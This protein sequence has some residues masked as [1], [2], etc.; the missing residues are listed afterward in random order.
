MVRDSPLALLGQGLSIALSGTLRWHS[1][2]R[3]SPLHGQGL[4]IAW[5][6]TLH[7][8]V[9]D[10]PL[11]VCRSLDN[12]LAKLKKKG[13]MVRDS[14]F[15]VRRSQFVWQV[16]GLHSCDFAA[17]FPPPSPPSLATYWSV[18]PSSLGPQSSLLLPCT[19]PGCPAW[20]PH[21]GDGLWSPRTLSVDRLPCGWG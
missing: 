12:S 1:L 7:C 10:S 20:P 2:A 15:H 8:I 9:R 6:G 16:Q 13:L 19:S 5:S 21:W 3:D 14:P 18:F 17:W 11:H 4:S